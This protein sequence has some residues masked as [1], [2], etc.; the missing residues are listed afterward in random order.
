MIDVK[1]SMSS[2]DMAL[3]TIHKP[4]PLPFFCDLLFSNCRFL[5]VMYS[6]A[7]T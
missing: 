6:N 3:I 4:D 1:V 7:G 2:V 5:L